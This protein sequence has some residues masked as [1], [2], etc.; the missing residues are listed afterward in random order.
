MVTGRKRRIRQP[1]AGLIRKIITLPICV[2]LQPI[3]DTQIIRIRPGDQR[4][5]PANRLSGAIP[6]IRY[7]NSGRSGTYPD[8]AFLTDACSGPV[9]RVA[10]PYPPVP[11]RH[12]SDVFLIPDPTG[13]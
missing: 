5:T 10:T 2:Q 3:Q 11:D 1:L 8:T 13:I 9:I 4:F 6:S 7:P 12:P